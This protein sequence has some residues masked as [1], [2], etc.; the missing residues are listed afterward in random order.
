MTENGISHSDN[1]R[2]TSKA[3]SV[4]RLIAAVA[5]IAAGANHFRNPGFY[6]RIIPPGFPSPQELVAISGVAEIVGG[7]GLLIRSLRRAAGWGLIALLVAVFPAN[8]Y[9]ALEPKQFADLH[10]PAWVL[11]ARL[12]LQAVFVAWVWFV[13]LAER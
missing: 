6:I 8:L 3:R 4:L 2:G 13:A 5:F 1:R 12:P 10:W 11:W 9:M 7:L